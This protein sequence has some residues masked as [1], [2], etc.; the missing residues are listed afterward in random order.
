M[1]N[2][3]TGVTPVKKF[4]DRS[5]AAARIWTA[6][7]SLGQPVGNE[8]AQEA[9]RKPESS[10]EAP[11]TETAPAVEPAQEPAPVAQ[12]A[13]QPPEA[14]SVEAPAKKKAARVKK[15][16]VA[17]EATESKSVRAGSKTET[18][19]ALMKQPG[20]TTLKAIM[21][22]TQWQAHSVRGFISGTLGKKMGLTVVSAKGENGER[23]YSISV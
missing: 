18:V 13:A 4:K 19:L 5:T 8:D 11:V 21:E 9:E 10:D 3:L 6:I 16:P 20:G 15:A 14:T 1:Y 23:N 12:E 17:T 2:S 22:V 7:Q